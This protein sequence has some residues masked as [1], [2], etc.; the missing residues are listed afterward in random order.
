TTTPNGGGRVAFLYNTVVHVAKEY[1]QSTA[2]EIAAFDW[3]DDNIVAPA[4][5]IGS[6][7][8]AAYNVIYDAA[9][10][11]RFYFPTSHTVIFDQNILPA[12]F[13]GRSNEWAGAGSGN[14]YVDPLLNL[15][16][17]AG[18][19]PTNAT[20]AQVR[21]ALQLLPGS[22]ALGAGFAGRNLGGLNASG[23]A[24]S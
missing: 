9:A 22:P 12:S 4:P 1:S 2:P 16:L 20:A 24:V 14:L 3:S 10:L 15:G 19:P 6:G 23:V 21:E 7:L 18:L 5:G 11:Q 17:L 13:K 8:Y